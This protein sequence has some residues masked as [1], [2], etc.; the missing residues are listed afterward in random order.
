MWCTVKQRC[1]DKLQ[2][3]RKIVVIIGKHTISLGIIQRDLTFCVLVLDRGS[4][5][6]KLRN[7]WP[8]NLTH[9]LG[10]VSNFTAGSIFEEMFDFYRAS[11]ERDKI[12]RASLPPLPFPL[13]ISKRP[14]SF[15]LLFLH[16]LVSLLLLT[17]YFLYS[18]L[19]V[20]MMQ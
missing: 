2:T 10:A 1:S 11:E 6:N 4:Y 14:E 15:Y 5:T 17:I 20:L 8:Y 18:L 9:V 13:F 12:L 7:T 3:A 16:F 19:V